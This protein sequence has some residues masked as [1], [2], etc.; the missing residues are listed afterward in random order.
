MNCLKFIIKYR[1]GVILRDFVSISLGKCIKN[2]I[3]YYDY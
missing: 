2:G 3:L 1:F